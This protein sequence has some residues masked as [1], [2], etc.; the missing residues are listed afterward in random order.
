MVRKFIWWCERWRGLTWMGAGTGGIAPEGPHIY[1]KDG[2]YY[3][4]IA[5]VHFHRFALQLE[6]DS[7]HP[8]RVAPA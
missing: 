6:P 8:R 4:M 5:E 1:K 2:W 7:S 3:L